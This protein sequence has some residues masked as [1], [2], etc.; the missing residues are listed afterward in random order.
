MN[1]RTKP[2]QGVQPDDIGESTRFPRWQ[3]QE[4]GAADGEDCRP[5]VAEFET[6]KSRF[7]KKLIHPDK[8]F[9]GIEPIASNHGGIGIGAA[10]YGGGAPGGTAPG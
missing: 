8:R 5:S 7:A 6:I 9:R 10:G 1:R 2:P 4:R 3:E